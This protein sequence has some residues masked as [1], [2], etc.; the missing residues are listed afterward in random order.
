V[1]LVLVV[2]V[3]VWLAALLFVLGLCMAAKQP[4]S[5]ACPDARRRHWPVRRQG[6]RTHRV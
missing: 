6:Q 4:S 1:I 2:V 3:A 5:R